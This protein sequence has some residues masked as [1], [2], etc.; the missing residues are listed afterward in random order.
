[1]RQV[2]E[3]IRKRDT[4]FWTFASARLLP[5]FVGSWFVRRLECTGNPES[6]DFKIQLM[7][8]CIFNLHC[9]P[10]DTILDLVPELDETLK[11]KLSGEGISMVHVGSLAVRQAIQTHQPMLGI[12]GHILNHEVTI[13]EN[14][15]RATE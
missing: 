12:H 5:L 7:K 8:N 2:T 13:F 6:T 15:I 9:P 4:A 1:V 14:G 10:Y 3:Y 11:P